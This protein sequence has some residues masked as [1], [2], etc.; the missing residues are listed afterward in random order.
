MQ[1]TDRRRTKRI[2]HSHHRE[3]E[4]RAR[5]LRGTGRVSS[6]LLAPGAVV[7]VTIPF[8]EGVGSKDRPAVVVGRDGDRIVVRAFTTKRPRHPAGYV[9]FEATKRNGL[10]RRSWLRPDTCVVAAEAV[11]ARRGELDVEIDLTEPEAPVLV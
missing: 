11:L 4:R 10:T 2:G 7:L 5:D 1:F 6:R 9:Q 8:R 3:A